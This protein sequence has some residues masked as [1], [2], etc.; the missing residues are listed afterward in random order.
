MKEEKESYKEI[1][2]ATSLFGGV[3]FFNIIFALLRSKAIAIFLGP[4]GFGIAGLINSTLNTIDGF[5]K[6]GL[7]TSAVKEISS[8]QANQNIEKASIIVSSLNRIIWF[9]GIFATVVLIVFSSLISEFTFGNDQF[10]IAFIWVSITLLFRQLTIGNIAV[11]Q[12]FRKRRYLAKANL[13]GSFIGLLFTIPLYY[14]FG[15]DAIVPS[16]IIS[17][18]IV[19]IFSK[20]YKIKLNIP[21]VKMSNKRAFSE[22][23]SMIKLGFLLSIMG[24]FSILTTYLSQIF[25][26]HYGGLEEVGFFIAGFV[27]INTYVGMIFNAMQTD[28]FPKLSAI[29]DNIEK[30]RNYV[31]EQ[32]Y[33]GILIITPIIVLFLTTTPVLI[34]LLYSKEFLLII[35]MVSWGM[36]GTLFKA[37]SFSMGYSILAK[38]DSSLFLKTSLVFN[39]L[40]L[41]ITIGGYV[42]GGLTGVGVGF[43]MYYFIHFVSLKWITHRRYQ[44]YFSRDFNLK[45]VMCIVICGITFLFSFIQNIWIKYSLMTIMSVFSVIFTLYHIDKKIGIKE[46]IKSIINKKTDENS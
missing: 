1:V 14:L 24:L 13:Y 11:L 9:T 22:G 37:V 16:I 5:T 20:Y 27:I 30:T 31:T 33:I 46:T 2:K 36:L 28:Y 17:T 34:T 3:Q 7:D 19:Y 8:A 43:L 41:I 38:G 21:T 15:L 40:L 12:G 26:N 44:I 18:I 6:L 42:L 32:A 25:I 39:T 29:S 4:M 35:G 23:M 10:S 45:F